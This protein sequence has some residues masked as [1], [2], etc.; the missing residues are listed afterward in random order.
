M[1][2]LKLKTT[3]DME[4][5]TVLSLLKNDLCISGTLIKRMKESG[6]IKLDNTPVYTNVR[7]RSNQVLTADIAENSVT[8]GAVPPF[9]ILYEDDD[10]LII[11]KPA[12]ML[13]HANKKTYS[14][15]TVSSFICEYLSTAEFHPVNR[16]DRGTSGVMV[17]AKN[18]YMHSRLIKIMHSTEFERTYIA[19]VCGEIKEKRGEIHL[20][21]GRDTIS[22]IKR[23]ITDSG[24]PACTQYEV[25]QVM[26]GISLIR[27]V[28]LTGRT[29]Q[30]RLH[31]SAIGHP[32]IG[33]FL[34]GTESKSISRYA[35]HSYSI[36]LIHPLTGE[37]LSIT[38]ELPDDMRS[39]LH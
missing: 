34:Y 16:L 22:P 15:K 27:I 7:V 21:I 3:A 35:L 19:L 25:M 1:R 33:D 13:V 5:R 28:P 12:G 6:G 9:P 39:L 30:I 37:E 32:L 4:G 23:I 36:K 24:K 17:I 20:P 29:H 8:Y 31:L 11:N 38:A 18:G 2:T 10:L 26:N 14:E